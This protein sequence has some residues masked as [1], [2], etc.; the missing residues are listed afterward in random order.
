MN[1][2][3][4]EYVRCI[5]KGNDTRYTEWSTDV[6][7]FPLTYNSQVTTTLGLSP[8]EMV[9]NQ[10]PRKPI[11]FTPNSSKNAQGYCQPTKESICYNLPLY[12]HDE[13][14]FHHPR[15]LK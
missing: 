1:R 13:D 7:L 12:T 8:N 10:K 5:L 9:F 2:S 3:L 14:H 6:K 11:L 4:Q 15:T